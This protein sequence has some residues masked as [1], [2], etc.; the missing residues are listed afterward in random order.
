MQM[1]FDTRS[2]GCRNY[3]LL[4][5]KNKASWTVSSSLL[6]RWGLSCTYNPIFVSGHPSIIT[7]STVLV[8]HH[9]LPL[10]W[11]HLASLSVMRKW[12]TGFTW[13]FV[14]WSMLLLP[15]IS[16]SW[17]HISNV[18]LC[19][20]GVYLVSVSYW[21]ILSSILRSPF[22]AL[23]NGFFAIDSIGFGLSLQLSS[24]LKCIDRISRMHK[25]S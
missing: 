2:N 24:F 11:A 21:D 5:Y 3:H 18:H 25:Q 22:G 14:F 9:Y 10:F 7:L 1:I 17:E 13:L 20:L 15:F 19:S 12:L 6:V 8:F 16:I 23:E 4:S